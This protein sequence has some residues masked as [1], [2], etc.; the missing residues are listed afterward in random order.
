MCRKNIIQKYHT[1]IYGSIE[2]R[3][4]EKKYIFREIL[5]YISLFCDNISLFRKTY[6][7]F[8]RNIS[9]YF[10]KNISLF[11]E[12]Y[13]VISRKIPCYIAKNISLFRE[14][15]SLFREKYL[16][17]SRKISRSRIYPGCI[18]PV[19]EFITCFCTGVRS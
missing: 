7:V 6:L 4:R 17:I 2:A 12:T 13:L 14:K 18:S 10:A 3:H 15:I 19:E 8:S 9:R 5:R 1:P 16:V 11:R